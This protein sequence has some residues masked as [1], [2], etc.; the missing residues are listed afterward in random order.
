MFEPIG[1]DTFEA[2]C[3]KIDESDY[4]IDTGCPVGQMNAMLRMY[5]SM[6][7]KRKKLFLKNQT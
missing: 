5:W 1:K 7:Q 4:V 6:Q 3:R 2:A